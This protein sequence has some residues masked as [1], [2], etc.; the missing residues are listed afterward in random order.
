MLYNIFMNWFL[1]SLLPP[2]LWAATNHFDKYLVSKYFKDGGVGALMVFSAIIGVFL[3]PIIIFIQSQVLHYS[4]QSILIAINGFLYLLATL[5][6]F[7]ALQKDEASV[8]IPLFQMIPVFSF[9]LAYLI[10]GETLTGHQIIGGLIVIFGAVAIT[11]DL[12]P[13]KAKF[14][15]EVFLLM[16]LSSLLYALNFLFFKYF[17]IHSDFWFV[18]FWEYI[19]FAIFSILIM[20]FVVPYRNQFVNVFKSNRVEVLGLNGINEVINIIAKAS[21]NFASL[22]VPITLIW[23]V[24]GFQSFFVFLFGVILTIFFPKISKENIT[25]KIL[26]QKVLAILIMFFGVYL[27]NK[28]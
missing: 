1:I 24:D 22:L 18:S 19:G 28:Q 13:E 15:K 8:C 26:I 17:A 10:I 20:V 3:L 7:Y 4:N 23:I 14:K 27:I 25:I 5:P 11:L 16:M 21:F 12:S 2:A 6:Y 9:I